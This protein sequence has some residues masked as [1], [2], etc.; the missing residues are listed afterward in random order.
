MLF[1]HTYPPTS[2]AGYAF[3]QLRELDRFRMSEHIQGSI[4]QHRIRTRVF[5]DRWSDAKHWTSAFCWTSRICG[6]TLPPNHT[7]HNFP[8]IPCIPLIS[9]SI[10]LTNNR[11]ATLVRYPSAT[12]ACVIT[13]NKEAMLTFN[14]A[15]KTYQQ[16]QERLRRGTAK[17]FDVTRWSPVQK[18]R[19]ENTA[20]FPFHWTVAI[21]A[22]RWWISTHCA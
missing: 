22:R 19:L 15:L 14:A 7:T 5:L 8:R 12:F 11:N 3:I 21:V 17:H 1:L 9:T 2:I 18:R 13:G 16:T 10:R 20:S 4:R 6:K